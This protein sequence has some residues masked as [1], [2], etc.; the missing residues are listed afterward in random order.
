MLTRLL[1]IAVFASIACRMVFK[2]WPWEY[3]SLAPNRGQVVLGA[4]KLLGV[5]ADAT[6]DE[7]VQAHRRLIA[8]VHP[9]RGGSSAQIHEAN[10]ARDLLLGELTHES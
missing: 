2:R 9:D 8:M 3:L 6:R 5:K 4:R 1:L 10:A 7:I